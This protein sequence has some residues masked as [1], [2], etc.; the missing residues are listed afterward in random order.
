MGSESIQRRAESIELECDA[1]DIQRYIQQRRVH[2]EGR[3]IR[4]VIFE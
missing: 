4:Y 2:F 1:A 3:T